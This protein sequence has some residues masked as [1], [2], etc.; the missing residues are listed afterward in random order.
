MKSKKTN[1]LSRVLILVTLILIIYT[2]YRTLVVKR[3]D[4]INIE[5]INLKEQ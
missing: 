5:G 2:A 3:I 4:I 1:Y